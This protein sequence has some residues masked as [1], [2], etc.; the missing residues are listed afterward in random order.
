MTFWKSKVTPAIPLPPFH[1]QTPLLDFGGGHYWRV[2][3]AVTGLIA[4]GGTGSGKTS[5]VA[6]HVAISFLAEGMGGLVLCGKKEERELWQGLVAEAGRA[7]DLVVFDAGGSWRYNFMEAECSRPG[8][9]GGLSINITS[10]LNELTAAISGAEPDTSGTSRFFDEANSHM[11]TNAVGL[12]IAAGLPITLPLL[13][14]IVTSAPMTPEQANSPSWKASST[15]WATIA[16]ADKKTA[17]GDEDARAD[18][19]ECRD[20][21]LTE[22][23]NLSEKTRSIITLV[24]SML[25]RPLITRPL[26]KAFSTDTNIKPEDT[27]D[28]KI[29]LVD[30]PV[31]EYRLVG[32][33]ANLVWKYNFQ[34]AVLRRTPPKEG[35]LRPVFLWADECQYFVSKFDSEFQATARSAVC[36]T[37]Y[38][39]Q[40]R[41]GLRRVLK[42]DD[43][44]DSLLGNLQT[45][46]FC[47]NTGDTNEFAAKLLGQHWVMVTGTNMG[48]SV[49]DSGQPLAQPQNN[50]GGGLN[51]GVTRSEQRRFFVEPS[52]FTTLKRGGPQNNFQV[53]AIVYAGGNQFRNGNALLPYKKL[54]FNQKQNT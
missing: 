52:V 29:I 2:I 46:F 51:S 15:C 18:F 24:F 47:Q 45:K 44:V 49:N 34:I 9:G 39:T 12:A 50:S 20:Y 54:T 33:I 16:E 30:I 53:E 38:F 4:F 1:P 7:D 41:E 32:R 37:A 25:V 17:N 42:N 6:K 31:Q 19:I 28:G 14:S 21:W 11:I 27:F 5:A 26:R 40:N 23:P 36:C 48:Q 3:E 13:R 8:A 43:A 35:Y 10:M 22:Y